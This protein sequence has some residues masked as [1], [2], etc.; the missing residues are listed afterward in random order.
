MGKK[1]KMGSGKSSPFS[2]YQDGDGMGTSN[3]P[4]GAILEDTGSFGTTERQKGMISDD[5][6]MS[7]KE[8]RQLKR[9]ARKLKKAAKNIPGPSR[10]TD[11]IIQNLLGT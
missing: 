6:K 1:S 5:E 4:K 2:N 3:R 9:K 8:K 11:T 10:G 7:R